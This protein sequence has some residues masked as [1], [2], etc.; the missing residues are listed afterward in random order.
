MGEIRNMQK[1][2]VEKPEGRRPLERFMRRWENIIECI[3][4]KYGG[5]VWDWIDLA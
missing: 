3:L 5:K 1:I 4:G 2:L